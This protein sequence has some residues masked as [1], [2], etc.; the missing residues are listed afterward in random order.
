MHSAFLRSRPAILLLAGSLLTSL[1]LGAGFVVFHR[2][3]DL[4]GV[5]LQQVDPMTGE[6]VKRQVLEPARHFVGAGRLE[7]PTASYLLMPCTTEERPPYQGRVYVNFDVPSITETPAYFRAIAEAMKARGWREGLPPNR[8]PGGRTLARDGVTAVYY[9][10]RE[11]PGRG[12]LQISGDCRTVTDYNAETSGF[13][14]IT[15]QLRP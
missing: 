10:D 6:Q 7:S 13:V 3:Y 5:A 2:I 9:R 8:H 11:V 12:V 15:G 4:G 1:V 14:D